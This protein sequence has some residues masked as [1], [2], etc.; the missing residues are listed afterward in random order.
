[1]SIE[2]IHPRKVLVAPITRERSIVRVQLLMPLAIM[3]P[4]KALA[5]PRPLALERF[6]FIVRSHMTYKEHNRQ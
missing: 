2:S 4:C 3:L 6:L 5:T 1:M